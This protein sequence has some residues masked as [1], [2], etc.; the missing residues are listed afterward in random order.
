MFVRSSTEKYA[1]SRMMELIFGAESIDETFRAALIPEIERNRRVFD[2]ISEA[3]RKPCFRYGDWT[4]P[5]YHIGQP[6]AIILIQ[7]VRLLGID[8]VFKAESGQVQEALGQLRFGMNFVRRLMDEPFLV[9]S[10]VALADMKSLLICLRRIS[11]DHDLDAET[12][13]AWIEELDVD[14]WRKEFSRY[15]RSERIFSLEVGLGLVRGDKAA[16]RA[17]ESASIKGKRL[18][19]WLVR[20]VLKSEIVWTQNRFFEVEQQAEIPFY[21]VKEVEREPARKKEP[22]PWYFKTIGALLANFEA[23]HLKEAAFEA[24]MLTTKAGLACEIYKD[25]N[26]RYPGSL[27]ALV[28]EILD[29]VPLDPFTGKPLTYR[30]D[31]SELIIYSF[32][33]NGRDDGGRTT[34]AINQLVAE[35]DDDWTWRKKID[36][37]AD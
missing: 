3:S 10:L 7:A 30:A 32:G 15:A 28:P 14:A 1:Q 29:E 11:V 20:P 18:F 13:S 37:K 23:T 27:E 17:L 12:M 2:F 31:D 9:R 26:G 25:E 8:A 34:Y 6:N 4:K 19:Y 22:L 36:P 33:S 24:L 35:K 16:R 5:Y 21:G